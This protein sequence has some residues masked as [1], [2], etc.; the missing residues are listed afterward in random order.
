MVAADIAAEIA[1]LRD[2]IDVLESR[3]EIRH[4]RNRFHDYV[5]TDRWSEIG[6]LFTEVAKLDYSYL[7][8]ESGRDAIGEFFGSIPKRLPEG[9]SGP[10][11]RQFIH[12]HTV[13][14]AGN[15][16][17]GS[18]H[19]FATPVYFGKSFLFAGRFADTYRRVAGR[20]LFDSVTMEVYY[21]V[22]LEEGWAGPDRHRLSLPAMPDPQE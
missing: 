12:G 5:N 8:Q 10:F 14:V 15:T 13:E 9:S 21:S 2:R 19:M 20:W 1:E 17:T 22:P 11:V 16:A 3:D 18:S 6:D 7:G 4:L